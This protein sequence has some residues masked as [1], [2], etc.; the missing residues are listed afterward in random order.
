MST[1]STQVT[2]KIEEDL[3]TSTQIKREASTP[4]GNVKSHPPASPVVK[5]ESPAPHSPAIKAESADEASDSDLPNPRKR[6]YGKKQKAIEKRSKGKAR[7]GLKNEVL[8]MEQ[9]L[10]A[11]FGAEFVSGTGE[12]KMT[13]L[14][15]FIRLE[16]ENMGLEDLEDEDEVENEDEGAMEVDGEGADGR[17]KTEVEE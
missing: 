13:T 5:Q 10:A 1:E 8:R 14:L 16:L 3:E 7:D 17:I 6:R 4:E 15:R 2:M 11:K 9:L 12:A